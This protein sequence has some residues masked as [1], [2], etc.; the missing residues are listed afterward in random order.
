MVHPKNAVSHMEG[1]V[2]IERKDENWCV[3][4]KNVQRNERVE[5]D[6][7][8][9]L[10]P[11]LDES[12]EVTTFLRDLIRIPSVNPPGNEAAVAAVVAAKLAEIGCDVKTYEAA[13]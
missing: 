10:I 3:A 9:F 4:Q 1:D 7:A 2:R 6:M 12:S 5:V 11:S 13:P 8:S